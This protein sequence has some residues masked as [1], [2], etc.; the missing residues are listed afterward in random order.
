V[1]TPESGVPHR[2][3]SLRSDEEE[4]QPVTAGSVARNTGIAVA[5]EVVSK[6]ASLA[7]FAVMAR[8]LGG[9]AFGSFVFAL[10]LGGVLVLAAGLGTDSLIE[11]EVAR[12]PSRARDYVS[13]ATR[14]KAVT[15]VSL[16]G[17]AAIGLE[18][19]GYPAESRVTFYVVGAGI[20]LEHLS[21]TR[22]SAFVAFQ[23][24]KYMS[25]SIVV[26]RFF[27][28]AGG[29]A[30]LLLGHGL[31]AASLM[32]LLGAAVGLAVSESSYRRLTRHQGVEHRPIP[33]RS[34]LRAGLPIGIASMLF[35]LLLRFDVVLLGLLKPGGVELGY[36]GAA[37][38]V[39]EAT[40]FLVWY[41]GSAVM[42]WVAR[43]REESDT[44]ARGYELGLKALVLLLLPLAVA[45]AVL[46]DPLVRLLY[47]PG[48]GPAVLPLQLLSA[49]TVLYGI[50]AMTSMFFIGRDRPGA[51]GRLLAVVVVQNVVFNLEL[52][53]Q[54][55]AVGAALNA[56][57]S[58]VLLAVLGFV[59]ARRTF[60]LVRVSRILLT[61]MIAGA[62]MTV[63]MVLTDQV[64]I[65][66]AIA[67]GVVY[68]V[69]L[70]LAERTLFPTDFARWQRLVAGRVR[71]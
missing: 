14:L 21:K 31:V 70:A 7:F 22:Y 18:F 39:I 29:V 11:R 40:L 37:Y 43:A 16:L 67:G 69:T 42:P 55:G 13:A 4:L 58:G 63:V 64:M 57:L 2:A 36:L 62:A 32:Y 19:A 52:I 9:A 15:C 24:M 25:L 20:V 10:S 71:R 34:L 45:I 23:R 47:G 5:G 60:G 46:A 26:Q 66:S 51:F 61:P 49:M 35:S 27:T 28:A 59:K 54:Y 17:A 48:Y 38:R 53:P 33:W 65:A 41:I 50:N 44:V 68:V 6:V 3:E 56:A 30:L 12:S 8:E 1:G